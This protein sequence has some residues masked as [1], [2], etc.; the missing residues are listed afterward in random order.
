MAAAYMFHMIDE[1]KLK[2]R[3]MPSFA[4]PRR[5]K[6]TWPVTRPAPGPVSARETKAPDID[7]ERVIYDPEYRKRVVRHLNGGAGMND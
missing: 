1:T 2:E 6:I 7:L 4:K 5:Q 3:H